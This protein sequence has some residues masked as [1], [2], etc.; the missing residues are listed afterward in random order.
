MEL[1]RRWIRSTTIFCVSAAEYFLRA[2]PTGKG[3]KPNLPRRFLSQWPDDH[4]QDRAG[5]SSRAVGFGNRLR[6]EIFKTRFHSIHFMTGVL[7]F[8]ERRKKLPSML[9]E[10]YPVIVREPDAR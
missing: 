2:E 6:A 1:F 10:P 7:N 5:V 8:P 9:P 3:S 4:S